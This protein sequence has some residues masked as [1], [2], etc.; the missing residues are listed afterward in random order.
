MWLRRYAFL[1]V[2]LTASVA[3]APE[4]TS[5]APAGIYYL[6]TLSDR[7]TDGRAVNASGQRPGDLRKWCA[8]ERAGRN[9]KSRP[10]RFDSSRGAWSAAKAT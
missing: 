10:A 2:L 7:Y 1:A 6:G 8:Q 4:P 3:W 9:V 5:A